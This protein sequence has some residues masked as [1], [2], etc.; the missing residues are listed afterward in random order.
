MD[1]GSWPGRGADGRSR[2]TAV[3]E[4][5]YCLSFPV[6]SR[7][8]AR[9]TTSPPTRATARRDINAMDMGASLL[10]YESLLNR[11]SDAA[12]MTSEKPE[13]SVQIRRAVA[14]KAHGFAERASDDTCTCVWTG[15]KE[16]RRKKEI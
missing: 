14:G 9:K 11:S 6:L 10:E 1:S 16:R 15:A 4:N 12:C 3:G 2:Q 7:R 5:C 13:D 8:G